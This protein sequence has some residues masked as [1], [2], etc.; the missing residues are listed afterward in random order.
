MNCM[1]CGKEILEQ[2]VFC[3]HC[4][5]V[6]EAYPVKPD[7]AIQLPNRQ[8]DA[9]QRKGV[10]RKKSVSLEEQLHQLK[11]ANRRLLWLCLIF[12]IL[13][14]ISIGMLIYRLYQPQFLPTGLA[15]DTTVEAFAPD[16]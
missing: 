2:Q 14:A 9:S 7:A 16:C 6:M 3:D 5:Q 8:L 11:A 1:K 12:A 13:W 15:A 10:N 4:L